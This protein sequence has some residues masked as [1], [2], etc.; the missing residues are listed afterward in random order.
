MI[1]RRYKFP[2][3]LV[4]SPQLNNFTNYNSP[5]SIAFETHNQVSVVI[6]WE[7]INLQIRI[8]ANIIKSDEK[9]K[10]RILVRSSSNAYNQAL[11]ASVIANNGYDGAKKWSK[12]IVE[13]LARS[14]K[15]NDRDQVKAIYSGLGDVAIVNSY[16]IGLLLS[17]KKEEERKA[18]E[19]V[20]VFFPNQSENQ[21]GTH[22]NISG[23]GI[24]KNA[25]NLENAI[26]LMNYLL[27]EEAQNTYVKNSYEY[28][29][30]K[31][32]KPSEIVQKWGDFRID[33][34][35]LNNLGVYREDAIE[36][37]ETTGWK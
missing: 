20:S 34:L 11:M 1:K 19:A 36:V 21:R 7:C 35:D 15:G 28:S 12:R 9:W 13:N 25:P 24:T 37:F 3:V 27:S 5:K 32:V 22:I 17:S 2:V 33:S 29:V 23:M 4:F 18:G 8:K 16:Y 31:S 26:K 6:Y 10:N 30:I 14:P